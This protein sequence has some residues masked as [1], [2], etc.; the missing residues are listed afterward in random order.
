MLCNK[1]IGI[2][3]QSLSVSLSLPASLKAL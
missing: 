2:R 1:A 3:G